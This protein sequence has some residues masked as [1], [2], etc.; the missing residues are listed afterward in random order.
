[1][2]CDS[3][4]KFININ[5]L[6]S[7]KNSKMIACGSTG[8]ALEILSHPKF[9]VR[10]GL[11]IDNGVN[12]VEHLSSDEIINSQIEVIKLAREKFPKKEIILTGITP[13]RDNLDTTISEVNNV[14]HDNIKV[15]IC[16]LTTNT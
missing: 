12:D 6:C 3:N 7:N 9:N 4:R 8:K 10:K 11:I 1:M 2:L 16:L 13:R 5:K 15:M 14:I